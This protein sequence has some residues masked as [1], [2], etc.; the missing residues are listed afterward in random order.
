MFDDSD[1][2]ETSR[3]DEVRAEI[4]TDMEN[5][6]PVGAAQIRIYTLYSEDSY[7]YDIEIKDIEDVAAGS[8]AEGSNQVSMSENGSAYYTFKPSI[9]A[10]YTFAPVG[11]MEIYSKIDADDETMYDLKKLSVSDGEAALESG[12]TYYIC[13]DGGVEDKWGDTQ[14]SWS[15]NVTR[16]ETLSN[17]KISS[18]K[19][20]D[21][22]NY[23]FL[24]DMKLSGIKT[25]WIERLSSLYMMMAV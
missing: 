24:P 23:E 17:S 12:N 5:E 18:W 8:L 1:S 2:V 20:R 10:R 6:C 19:L 7:A 13:F 16:G 3:G 11:G 14:T 25:F 15:M 22:R 21:N 9:S 4:V